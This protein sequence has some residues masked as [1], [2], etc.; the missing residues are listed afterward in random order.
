MS[1]EIRSMLLKM[2]KDAFDYINESPYYIINH[3]LY[4]KGKSNR[5]L[6]A[7]PD[8]QSVE[9]KKQKLNE[10]RNRVDDSPV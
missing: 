3:A 9:E 2:A 4:P 10:L 1:T 6:K 7:E 5:H 8:D